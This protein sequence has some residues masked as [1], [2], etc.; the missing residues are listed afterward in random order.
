MDSGQIL[1][2]IHAGIFYNYVHIFLYL[3]VEIAKAY[4]NYGTDRENLYLLKL[5]PL[6]T[7]L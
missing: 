2:R 5:S 7:K 4:I 1:L 6:Y 3:N